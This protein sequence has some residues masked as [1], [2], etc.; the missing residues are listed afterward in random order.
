MI[1]KQP[2]RE[3]Q[4]G[5]FLQRIRENALRPQKARATEIGQTRTLPR[6]SEKYLRSKAN[7]GTH[8]ESSSRDIKTAS[9]SCVGHLSAIEG[10][11]HAWLPIEL[12]AHGVSS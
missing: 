12:T 1:P 3:G 8:T 6:C 9:Q 11:R 10:V 7:K 4:I 5:V 2:P